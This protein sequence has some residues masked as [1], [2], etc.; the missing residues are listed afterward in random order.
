MLLSLVAI[1]AGAGYGLAAVVVPGR[2]MAPDS[3]LEIAVFTSPVHTDLVLPLRHPVMDWDAFLPTAAF[4]GSRAGFT[5][6][7]IGW[8]DRGFFLEAETWADLRLGTALVALSGSGRSA[9]HVEFRTAPDA[10]PTANGFSMTRATIDAEGYRQLVEFVL[11]SFQRDAAGRPVPIA[12]PGYCYD[13]RDAFFEAN[14]SYSLFRT[15]NV[16]TCAALQR[17]GLP[18]PWWSPFPG[19]VT[20]HLPPGR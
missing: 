14:G 7:A 16:W 20:S 13:G 5:H 2:P 15:C 3:T 9:M 6:V 4:G 11:A 19:A 1:Y 10:Y 17:A 18:T 12:A 8:G